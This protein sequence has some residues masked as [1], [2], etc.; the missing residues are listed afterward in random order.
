M[1]YL[2]LFFALLCTI[3]SFSQNGNYISTI[4]KEK[5]VIDGTPKIDSDFVSYS[6]NGDTAG[7][8]ISKINFIY[9][10]S[11]KKKIVFD[12]NLQPVY[13]LILTKDSTKT[14]TPKTEYLDKKAEK[15]VTNLNRKN[16]KNIESKEGFTTAIFP[17]TDPYKY[18]F[19]F[20]PLTVF[21]IN[22]GLRFS[23]EIPI[24]QRMSWQPDVTYIYPGKVQDI[25]IFYDS[26]DIKS[27]YGAVS[28]LD[29]RYYISNNTGFFKWYLSPEVLYRYMRFTYYDPGTPRNQPLV[30]YGFST[31]ATEKVYGL[32]LRFGFT[33]HFTKRIMID[34]YAG[35][36]RKYTTLIHDINDGTTIYTLKNAP[37]V[38]LL[39]GTSIGYRFNK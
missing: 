6:R 19:S 37:S 9:L 28:R 27:F 26:L 15:D 4:Y 7:I 23:L 2:I 17:I 3:V 5:I 35:A 31:F 22:R 1:K 34:T 32:N 20:Y 18:T 39:F 38:T 16:K 36:G 29:F 25:F 10:E 12:K 13:L 14:I 21:E 30:V 11:E 24:N 8:A 33:Y